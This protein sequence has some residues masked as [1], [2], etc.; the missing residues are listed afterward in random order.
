MQKYSNTAYFTD[1]LQSLLQSFLFKVLEGLW[2]LQP[3]SMLIISSKVKRQL[4]IFF[5]WLG[6]PFGFLDAIASLDLV[7]GCWY[8]SLRFDSQM[9][10]L[11]C[12]RYVVM[13]CTLSC[14]HSYSRL[15]VTFPI[16]A[17]QKSRSHPPFI[18]YEDCLTM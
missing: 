11:I 14:F 1:T 15:K 13:S 2:W 17:M 7:Y 5:F 6:H 10:H 12:G 16:F 8:V 9:G 3:S 18:L 4:I